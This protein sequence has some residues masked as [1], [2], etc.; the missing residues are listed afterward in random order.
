MSLLRWESQCQSIMHTLNMYSYFFYKYA[1]R[2]TLYS[3]SFESD[4]TAC[5]NETLQLLSH[6]RSHIYATEAVASDIVPKI[7]PTVFKCKTIW[8]RHIMRYNNKVKVSF[9]G[10]TSYDQLNSFS[11]LFSEKSKFRLHS[12]ILTAMVMGLLMLQ[13]LK[14]YSCPKVSP[15]N[16]QVLEICNV[17][18]LPGRLFWYNYQYQ[19]STLEYIFSVLVLYYLAWI[20]PK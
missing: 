2:C 7:S 11:F 8:L 1:L 14:P 13:R 19:C 10:L 18:I 9:G 5:E 3:E 20:T 17:F 12:E 4:I 6:G 15:T 16:R